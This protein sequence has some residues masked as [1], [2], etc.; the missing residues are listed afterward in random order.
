MRPSLGITRSGV[1]LNEI[2]DLSRR[3]S[4]LT[5]TPEKYANGMPLNK[6][7]T[8]LEVKVL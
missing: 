8:E 1:W 4:F 5:S 3:D 2:R 6:F 7:S